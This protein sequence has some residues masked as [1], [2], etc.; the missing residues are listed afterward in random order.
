MRYLSIILCAML[1]MACQTEYHAYDT[2]VS[3]AKD[4]HSRNIPRIEELCAGKGEIRFAFLSDTQ[5]WYDEA[6]DAVRS[7]NQRTDIDFV[8]HGGDMSDWSLRDEFERQRDILE[9]LKVPYVVIIG[10]HDCLVTGEIVYRKLFGDPHFAFTAGDVRFV[11]ANTNAL[12]YNPSKPVPDFDFLERELTSFP[13]EARRTVALMH[14]APHSEQ[15]YGE[16]ADQYHATM[17]RFPNLLVA[18]HGHGHSYEIH[19]IF[20]D[21][22]L[23][24]QADCIEKR[25]YLVFTINEEGYTHEQ[26]FF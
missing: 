13:A 7:I 2:D 26:V 22:L 3:G 1:F 16:K 18:I 21:G 20:E 12:E 15:L 8:V 24:I 25:N 14:A 6:E 17:R 4:I 19:D 11:C 10:N 5:R 23:Y 9:G